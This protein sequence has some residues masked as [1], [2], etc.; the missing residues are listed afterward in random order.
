MKKPKSRVD[1]D[2]FPQVIN[3]VAQYI[4][5]PLK[6]IYNEISLTGEWPAGWKKE[7]VTAI[8]KVPHPES[9]DDFRNISCTLFVSKVYESFVLGWLES[10]IGVRSNQFGGMKGAGTEHFLLETWQEYSGRPGRPS[11][12]NTANIN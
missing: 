8:P 3:R 2:T 6:C 10:Q 4:A 12:S 9:C 5:S 7:Q 1:G 11:S